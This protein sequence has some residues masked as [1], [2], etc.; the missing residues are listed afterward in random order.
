MNKS[1][2]KIHPYYFQDKLQLIEKEKI[3]EKI[4]N[5]M[6]LQ[7]EAL[8]QLTIYKVNNPSKKEILQKINE[9]SYKKGK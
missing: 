2:N 1:F 5:R 8:K 7:R 4:K 3:N 6:S 9:L